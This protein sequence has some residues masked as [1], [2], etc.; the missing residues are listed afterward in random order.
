MCQ[1]VKALLYF[2]VRAVRLDAANGRGDTALHLAARWGYLGVVAVLLENGARPGL[3]NHRRETALSLA[4]N[5]K[6]T[7]RH[8]IT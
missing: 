4:L 6:V 2:E 3:P 5:A 7:G 1:C 8:G